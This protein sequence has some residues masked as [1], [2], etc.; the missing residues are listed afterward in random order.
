MNKRDTAALYLIA[1][2]LIQAGKARIEKPESLSSEL[3]G[4]LPDGS[5]VSLGNMN[6]IGTLKYLI[7]C[8]TPD[9]W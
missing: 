7:A 6:E 1:G 4:I 3:I 5:E 9:R 8:P 2:A